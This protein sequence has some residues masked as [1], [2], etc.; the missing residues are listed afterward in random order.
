MTSTV[1]I[2]DDLSSNLKQADAGGETDADTAASTP[3]RSSVSSSNPE[4][5]SMTSPT[6][7][8]EEAS[9]LPIEIDTSE[10]K[11]STKDAVK[12]EEG[13]EEYSNYPLVDIKEPHSNDVLYGRGGG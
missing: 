1:K 12:K 13:D 11:S 6:L 8:N 5:A 4:S 7:K 9:S 3:A 2:E 10:P